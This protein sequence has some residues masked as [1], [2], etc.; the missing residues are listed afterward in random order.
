MNAL[1]P[2]QARL[3]A[4]QDKDYRD[5]HSKLIPNIDK[6]LVIGIRVPVL[7]A[8]AKNFSKEDEASAFINMLPHKYYEENC[9]HALLIE[10]ISD[11]GTLIKELD[12]FL[13]FI[14]N[15]AA[16]DILSPKAFKKHPG[17]FTAKIK[18]WIGSNNTYAVRFGVDMLLKFYLDQ[19][20]LPVYNEWVANIISDEYYINMARA[21]YFATALAKQ[22]DKTVSIIE[23]K[24]LDVFTHNKT[25]QKAIESYRI[26]S[27]QKKYLKSLKIK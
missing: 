18:E 16:C 17:A 14:D 13:P 21:W 6:D 27:E 15:W 24:R 12:R 11:C 4:L 23:Q 22:Y 10:Q 20:F 3:F 26:G 7:R 9:L 25:V 19:E 8:F 5:F 2:L 1:T